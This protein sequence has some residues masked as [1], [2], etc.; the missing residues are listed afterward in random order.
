[1]LFNRALIARVVRFLRCI[2]EIVRRGDTLIQELVS[3]GGNV[4]YLAHVR[5]EYGGRTHY[6][7]GTEILDHDEVTEEAEADVG[8][9]CQ[10][11]LLWPKVHRLNIRPVS[12]RHCKKSAIPATTLRLRQHSFL[13]KAKLRQLVPKPK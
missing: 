7:T 9:S 6:V 11:K 5:Y 10:R 2:N 12:P 4:S 13:P 1:M 3:T 8:P